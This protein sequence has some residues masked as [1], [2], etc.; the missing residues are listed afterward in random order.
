MA[1]QA[2]PQRLGP[3]AGLALQAA[4]QRPEPDERLAP[5]V[6]AALGVAAEP[7]SAR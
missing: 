7:G 1:L 2:A 5:P 4:P 6:R 3:D